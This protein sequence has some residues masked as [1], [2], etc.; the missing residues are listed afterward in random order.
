VSKAT[1]RVQFE[2]QPKSIDR[3]KA[4]RDRT[5]AASY[6]EVVRRAL[7][8]FEFV[9]EEADKGSEL[10]IRSEEKGEVRYR[11]IF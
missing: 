2:M 3:L 10:S 4:L 5:E 8:L 6:A 1:T 7:Q 11:P 9:V